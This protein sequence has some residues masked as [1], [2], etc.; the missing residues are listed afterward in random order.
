MSVRYFKGLDIFSRSGLDGLRAKCSPWGSLSS[1]ELHGLERRGL[2][3]HQN[4]ERRI[5]NH[6]AAASSSSME[7]HEGHFV[8]SRLLPTA[9][10]AM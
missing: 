5:R 9:T 4:G 3:F 1:M 2:V 10:A 6:P 8:I 7:E